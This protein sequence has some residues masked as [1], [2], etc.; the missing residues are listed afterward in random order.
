MRRQAMFCEVSGQEAH[1]STERAPCEP[2]GGTGCGVSPLVG[3]RP[4]R[5][6]RSHGWEIAIL[7]R[8][9]RISQVQKHKAL[10]DVMLEKDVVFGL[11]ELWDVGR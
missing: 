8:K 5:I 6:Q 4:G 9:H 1:R 10:K 3:R 2:V 7:T 11:W